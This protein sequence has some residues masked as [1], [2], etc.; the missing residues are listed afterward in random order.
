MKAQGA[1]EYLILIA[2]IISVTA[3]V[4][5]LTVNYSGARQDELYYA[6]C[7]QAASTCGI[8]LSADQNNPCTVCNTACKYDDDTEIFTGAID[9]CKCGQSKM[10][11]SG[12]SGCTGCAELPSQ[13][14]PND[15]K[16]GTEECDG[17]DDS[18]CPNQCQSDCTCA[19]LPA[20]VCLELD[21]TTVVAEGTCSVTRP[22]WRCI[23]NVLVP[24]CSSGCNC[25][26]EYPKCDSDNNYCYKVHF[27]ETN[28]SDVPTDV[29]AVAVGDANN[30]GKN[31]TVV[32]LGSTA[33]ETRMYENKSGGWIETNISDAPTTVK[34]IAIGDV[35]NDGKNEVVVGLDSANYELR[36]YENKSGGWIESYMVDFVYA[37]DSL[38][39]GDANN[40]GKNETVVGLR[41]TLGTTINGLRM[42]ENKAGGWVETIL[43]DLTNS[44]ISVSIGDANND[45]KNEVVIGL[46]STANETRMYENKSGGWIETNISDAPTT[47]TSV[48]LRDVNNDGKNEI[49]IGIYP[50]STTMCEIRMYENKS[51][52]W[53]ETSISYFDNFIK[54]IALGD[55]DNDGKNDITIG[56]YS[57]YNETR[58]YE[59]MSGKWMETNI[60]NLIAPLYSLVLGD[61][62]NDGK[63]EVVIG[64]RNSMQPYA[65]YFSVCPSPYTDPLPPSYCT[66]YE[67]RMY[68]ADRIY[69]Y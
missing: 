41:N 65:P 54:N 13:L 3:L 48:G 37:I 17:L 7:Q 55:A 16:E 12:S 21:G 28:I 58:M 42:Y 44:V 20:P 49:V 26:S 5:L 61:A 62:N 8:L 52:G 4:T 2:V 68:T 6:S 35:N 31:E 27:K 43:S 9:C 14:C 36:M 50:T 67:V 15:I 23:N 46:S 10:I 25:Q 34:H 24:A 38:A 39:I 32:G 56:M 40:D 33:N 51:G 59:N 19:S 53:V 22:G 1:P 18:A 45:G 60:S 57:V 63:N 64:M 69:D 47:V 11:Y 29:Y 66:I 30:D